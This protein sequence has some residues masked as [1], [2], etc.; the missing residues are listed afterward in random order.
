VN[1]RKPAAAGWWRECG[2]QA[3]GPRKN[4]QLEQLKTAAGL[5][6]CSTGGAGGAGAG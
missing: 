5:V 4:R 1:K 2:D 6:A 3:G